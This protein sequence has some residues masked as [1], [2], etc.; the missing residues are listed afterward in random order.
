MKKTVTLTSLI[1]AKNN[2]ELYIKVDQMKRLKQ[3]FVPTFDMKDLNSQ[4]DSKEN[5]LIIVKEAI[6]FTNAT[7]KDESGNSLNYSIYQLS[8]YNRFK[9]DLLTIRDRLKSDKFLDNNEKLKLSLI[10]DIEEL[11]DLIK[12]DTDKKIAAEHRAAKAKLKKSLSKVSSTTKTTTDDLN[13]FVDS[14]LKKVETIIAQIKENLTKINGST[15]IDVEVN[16][17]FEFV[18]K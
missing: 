7:T 1:T 2:L 11:D 12:K 8:K 6:A 5:Q 18:I 10:K 4:I 16:E 17:G 15:N 13:I 14:E 9:S 3:L